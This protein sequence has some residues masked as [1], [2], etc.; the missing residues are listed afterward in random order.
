MGRKSGVEY[1][2]RYNMAAVNHS[3]PAF[4]K[5]MGSW[6]V[7]TGQVNRNEWMD[8]QLT[9]DCYGSVRTCSVEFFSIFLAEIKQKHPVRWTGT[10]SSVTTGLAHLMAN[11]FYLKKKKK[12]LLDLK[13]VCSVPILELL[14]PALTFN[15]A[16][17][18][19]MQ[20]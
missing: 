14:Y 10:Y 20:P 12:H 17:L 9:I 2:S 5:Q 19:V 11:A 4:P 8:D 6:G 18:I 3:S 13:R 1:L 7:P 16:L 15:D